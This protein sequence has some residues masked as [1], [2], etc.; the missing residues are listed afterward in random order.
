MSFWL[1]GLY[2]LVLPCRWFTQRSPADLWDENVDNDVTD[3]QDH[4]AVR[5]EAS[6]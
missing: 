6:R 4:Y 3:W 5:K 1:L 2:L